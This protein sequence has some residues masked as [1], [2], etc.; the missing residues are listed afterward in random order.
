MNQEDTITS[1]AYIYLV[2][3]LSLS[4]TWV[5]ATGTYRKPCTYIFLK[6]CQPKHR[7]N[8]HADGRHQPRQ[9]HR[10]G[11]AHHSPLASGLGKMTSCNG[12]WQ[13]SLNMGQTAASD[14]G[15]AV[16]LPHQGL[17][18]GDAGPPWR[19]APPNR[20]ITI[21]MLPCCRIRYLVQ[22]L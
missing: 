11:L 3:L 14:T 9:G 21:A 19:R 16:A 8:H 6:I 20:E 1:A 5:R 13:S 15:G 10:R 12:R 4:T 2:F 7:Q 18:A 17:V 22:C